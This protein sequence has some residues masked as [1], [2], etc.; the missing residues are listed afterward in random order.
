MAE[1]KDYWYGRGSDDRSDCCQA[2][3]VFAVFVEGSDF[4]PEESDMY[5]SICNHACDFIGEVS[6]EKQVA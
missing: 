3:I 2:Q 4:E 5:C 1:Y 6:G